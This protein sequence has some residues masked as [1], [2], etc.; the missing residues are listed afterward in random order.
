MG[1]GKRG[2]KKKR[3]KDDWT[4]R[5]QKEKDNA[6]DGRDI[7]LSIV[8]IPVGRSEKREGGEICAMSAA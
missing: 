5:F 6:Y 1:E 7:D 8:G 2:K 3:E 4:G